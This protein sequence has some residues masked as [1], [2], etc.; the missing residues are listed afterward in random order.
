MGRYI[1][2]DDV[3]HRFGSV[4]ADFD[5]TKI[6]SFHIPY[7][8]NMV[9]ALLAP[10]Y[11]TPFSSNNLTVKDLCIELTYIRAGGLNIK[12]RKELMEEFKGR[13]ADLIAG[14]ES[15]LDG[16]GAVIAQDATAIAWSSEA[17]YQ[18]T[19]GHGDILDAE[20]D[21][22]YVDDEEDAK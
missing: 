17:N 10:K 13:I 3:A 4:A 1:E 22:D 11:T 14:V 6:N 19:F 21:Q 9:D 16:D 7:S 5:S 20:M 8:E 18:P 15:M 2:W 12:D